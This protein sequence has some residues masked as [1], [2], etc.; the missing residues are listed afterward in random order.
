MTGIE[1]GRAIRILLVEDNPGDVRLVQEGFKS[2]KVANEL[3]TV[4]DGEA[5][6]AFLRHEGRFAQV[7][8]PDL[9]LLD[10]NLPRVGGMEVLEEIR[11]DPALE[12]LV[13]VVLTTSPLEEDVLRSY[14]QRANCF[15]RKPVDFTQFV[16]IVRSIDRFW[17]SIVQLPLP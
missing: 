2:G 14:R 8:L 4:G 9:V 1:L 3:F 17:F 16:E 11:R 6:L 10:L 7:P 12:H 5:A 15:I 13:V